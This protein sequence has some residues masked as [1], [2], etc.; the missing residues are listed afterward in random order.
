MERGVIG[1]VELASELATEFLLF[2][3]VRENAVA[4]TRGR[5]GSR[6]PLHDYCGYRTEL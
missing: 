2:T 5:F 6:Q 3:A 1:C 4:E